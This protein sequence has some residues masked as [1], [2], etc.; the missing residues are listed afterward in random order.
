MDSF[1]PVGTHCTPKTNSDLTSDE[2]AS[3]T[4]NYIKAEWDMGTGNKHGIQTLSLAGV[5][6]EQRG[7]LSS[8]ARSRIGSMGS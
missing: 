5:S 8:K 3:S 1:F 7:A 4:K 6:G 2:A